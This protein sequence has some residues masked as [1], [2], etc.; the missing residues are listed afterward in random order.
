V[1]ALESLEQML[2]RFARIPNDAQIS[3]AIDRVRLGQVAHLRIARLTPSE[4]RRLAVA[5]V[6]V[7]QPRIAL[8]DDVVD[9]HESDVAGAIHDALTFLAC[10]GTAVLASTSHPRAL[11]RHATRVV[12]LHNGRIRAP[13]E[14]LPRALEIIVDQAPRVAAQL[15]KHRPARSAGATTIRVPL[16]GGSAEDVLAECHRLGIAVHGSR[17]VVSR[18]TAHD[19]VAEEP[20]PVR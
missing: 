14:A 4:L 3:D 12:A 10:L 16:G 17:I 6:L 20:P 11:V 13:L 1:T 18:T 5:E 19:R 8:L 2:L 7:A 15:S 9:G